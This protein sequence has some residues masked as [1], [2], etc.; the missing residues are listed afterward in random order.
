MALNPFADGLNNNYSTFIVK[1]NSRKTVSVMGVR[2]A[3]GA[4]YN[5]M[6]LEGVTEEDIKVSLLKGVL[7]RKLNNGE[8]S[9]LSS[10]IDLSSDN[11]SQA[12]FISSLVNNNN[13]VFPQLITTVMPQN[14]SG[15][16]A[17]IHAARLAM[18]GKG[19]VHLGPGTFLWQGQYDM[20]DNL[21]E[22]WHPNTIIN[23]V[24]TNDGTELNAPIN[25]NRTSARALLTTTNAITTR[26]TNVISVAS[27][28]GL[29][30]GNYIQIIDNTVNVLAVMTYLITAVGV[31]NFTVDR[32]I[33]RTFP[34]NSSIY[35]VLPPKNIHIYGNGG[36]IYSSPGATTTTVGSQTLPLAT[37]NVSS[38]SGFATS[39]GLF[40][41]GQIVFYTGKTLTSFTGCTGGSGLINAGASVTT[42]AERGIEIA[43]GWN[44]SVQDL[45]ILGFSDYIAG[46]DLGC[47]NCQFKNIVSDA[48]SLALAA[49]T[50]ESSEN[51]ELHNCEGL[52]ATG[53][54]SGGG[55]FVW[56][57]FNCKIYGG[58]FH[59]NV[60]NGCL[61]TIGGS[62]DTQG[63]LNLK[64]FGVA[65]DKN[66]QNGV[67]VSN[68]AS[69]T[70]FHSCTANYNTLM[71]FRLDADLTQSSNT[72]FFGGIAENNAGGLYLNGA[73]LYN[74]AF[75][76]VCKNNVASSN[77]N[78]KTNSE[79]ECFSCQSLDPAGVLP[80][81]T[82]GLLVNGS[83][84]KCKWNGGL[85]SG[86]STAGSY[87]VQTANGGELELS[88]VTIAGTG[89]SAG[90]ALYHGSTTGILKLHRVKSSGR[91][92]D[93]GLVLA[94]GTIT[95]MD[96]CDF[97]TA[98]VPYTQTGTAIVR[99]ARN[100]SSGTLTVTGQN[101]M[102]FTALTYSASIATDASLGN[103]FTIV[104]TN[105][106]AFTI[107]SPTNVSKGQI[108]IYDI[109]NSSG[110]AMGAITW[111]A[112]FL[113]AGA[114]TNPANTKRRTI[115]FYYDGTNWVENFRASADI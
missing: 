61:I 2:I 94:T 17:R 49:F 107:T 11:S 71:G 48:N 28:A 36:L 39:G 93:Y 110:G 68:A 103:I 85:I 90:Y 18:S 20:P 95:E 72:Q 73:T 62:S 115:Q 106:T 67:L 112:T 91:A 77:F 80:N 104:A 1:N 83:G 82:A 21:I 9:I 74:K 52:K 102:G 65:F 43:G 98:G 70:E 96:E 105:G 54:G 42:H 19:E 27:T 100:I 31:G 38:T 64:F 10:D 46:Y 13:Q 97:S 30:V 87:G 12:T 24:N 34:S 6:S 32:P 92:S 16:A 47:Y 5:L 88:N 58:N 101:P 99:C 114:F 109:K 23:V 55:L 14:N 78:I 60:G 79:L 111:G 4:N 8:I 41:D 50:I 15:D 25:A 53:V 75:G 66:T 33:L 44:C 69:N 40:V 89:V 86:D 3:P 57:S 84:A 108:I 45:R 51:I 59:N 113:L 81:S 37:I 7:K 26:G 56:S 76:L 63:C 35:S 22:K 29:V